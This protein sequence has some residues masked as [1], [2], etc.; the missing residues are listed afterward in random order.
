[1][2]S[3]DRTDANRCVRASLFGSFGQLDGTAGI[4]SGTD[5]V[6]I[7]YTRSADELSWT[8]TV[9]N[10]ITGVALSSFTHD[11]GPMTGYGTGTECDNSC[12]GTIVAQ[13]YLN[14]TIVLE[15]ADPD[16]SNTLGVSGGTTY[17]GLTSEEGGRIWKIARIDIPAMV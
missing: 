10:A 8:Q 3:W 13:Q 17:T 4:V 9:T 6:L 1:M 7:N 12:S 14:T 2:G 16:F 11:S 15:E 5:H